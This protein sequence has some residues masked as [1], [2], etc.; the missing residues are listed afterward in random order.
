MHD[1]TRRD[2]LA[3]LFAI[4]FGTA[5]AGG[6]ALA[7][8]LEDSGLAFASAV[9]F[10]FETLKADA[11]ARAR[12]PW[13]DPTSPYADILEEIDYTAFH[14]I[15]YRRDRALWRT[16]DAGAPVQLF[17]VGKYFKEPCT[18]SL[19]ESGQAREILGYVRFNSGWALP[20]TA[21]RLAAGQVDHEKFGWLPRDYVERYE[22]DRRYTRGKWISSA[23]D[24]RLHSSIKDGWRIDCEH[25]VVTT[26]HSLE[27]G[28]RLSRRLEQLFDVWRHVFVDYYTPD[29]QMQRWF[30]RADSPSA[31]PP[32]AVPCTEPVPSPPRRRSRR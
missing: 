7:A 6:K 13:R 27:E 2:A 29:T 31:D 21:R 28:V 9:P 25:Y 26:N 14:Q 3:G 18:I 19:V 4:A 24:E 10:S 20:D 23:E 32:R 11:A 17:H 8:A 16:G 12:E 30:E 15:N 22:Q 1:M 5:G